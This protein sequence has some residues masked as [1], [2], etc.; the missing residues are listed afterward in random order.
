MNLTV[1]EMISLLRSAVNVPNE[2]A[3]LT[4]PYLI[5]MS[6][7]DIT[8]FLKLGI[9]R[10]Y[11]NAESFEELPAWTSYP[12]ILCSKKEL[13]LKLAVVNA[14]LY[15]LTADNNNQLKRDQRFKHY[16]QLAE[17]AQSEFEDW[18][19]NGGS[20]SIDPETGLQG[21]YTVDVLRSKNHYTLRNYEH[22][23]KP[24]VSISVKSITTNSIDFMWSSQ[25]N[26]HF[27]VFYVYLS[28]KPIVNIF[29]DG[30]T[31]KEK[32]EEGAELILTSYNFRNT[33][34]S[35]SDLEPN[36][37]YHLAVFSVERNQ[38]FGFKEIIFHTLSEIDT[39]TDDEDIPTDTPTENS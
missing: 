27:G 8:L 5:Q 21:V 18:E 33:Y 22:Q 3:E 37:D 2:E 23:V 31:A 38:L 10:I 32:V 36:K 7:E 9:S 35:I 28:E 19:D 4:D 24:I 25:A 26:E 6:D 13:Y 29:K 11:P 16:M 17:N 1:S 14:P 20:D 34:H 30:W 12:I 39:P 15:D